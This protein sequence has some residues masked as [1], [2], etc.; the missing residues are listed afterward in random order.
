MTRESDESRE[1]IAFPCTVAIKAIGSDDGR[2]VETVLAAIR[3]I[4]PELGAPSVHT[5]PSRNGRYLSVTVPVPFET[6][7]EFEA[8]YAALHACPGVAYLL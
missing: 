7:E 8:V 6:R 5:R 1:L 2:F 4:L 3:T